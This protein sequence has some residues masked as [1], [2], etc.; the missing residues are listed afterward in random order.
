MES[1]K[2]W[3]KEQLEV[4]GYITR[5]TCLQN[6]ISRLSAIIQDLELDGYKF[7]TDYQKTERGKDYIYRLIQKPELKLF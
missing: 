2:N 3:V 1:Q 6:F 7:E 5:N 4:D